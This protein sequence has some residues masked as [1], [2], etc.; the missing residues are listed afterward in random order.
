[1]EGFWEEIESH[2]NEMKKD[3]SKEFSG[4]ID[5]KWMSIGRYRVE[6]KYTLDPDKEV[7]ATIYS[8]EFTIK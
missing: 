3:T 5:T 4:L 1:M 8:N 2:L 6:F 7:Q